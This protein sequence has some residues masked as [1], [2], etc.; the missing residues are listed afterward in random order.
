MKLRRIEKWD[1]QKTASERKSLSNLVIYLAFKVN[2]QALGLSAKYSRE[3][4][5]QNRGL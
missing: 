1:L 3:H 4:H 2:I 5:N